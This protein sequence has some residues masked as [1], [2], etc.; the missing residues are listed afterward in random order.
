MLSVMPLAVVQAIT[1][2]LVAAVIAGGP[3]EPHEPLRDAGPVAQIIVRLADNA[4][5]DEPGTR[6]SGARC[7]DPGN[8][9]RLRVERA[10]G[11][12]MYVVRVRPPVALGTA[13]RIVRQLGTCPGVSWAEAPAVTFLPGARQ[14]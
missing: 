13:R 4:P 5:V 9:V 12:G 2:T 11:E 10:L 8:R 7:V 3:G 6:P 14:S 1:G